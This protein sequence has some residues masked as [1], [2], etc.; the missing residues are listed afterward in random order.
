MAKAVPD[1]P[2]DDAG[3]HYDATPYLPARGGLPALRRAASACRGCPLFRDATQTVFGRGPA[4]ARLMLVGEQPGDREDVQG[5]PFVGP[6]GQLLRR[7]L[8][9]AGLDGEEAYLTNVVKHF[10]FTPAP[11]GK[12]RI[13]QAPSLREMTACRPWLARELRLVA[14]E[15]LVV[16]GATAG[17]ALLGPS[18]RVGEQRGVL[19]PMPALD[20]E[21]PGTAAAGQLLATVHPSAV[22]RADD[23]EAAFAGLVADLSVAATVLE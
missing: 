18:F 4:R 13:H 2:G 6:A 14:P 16:L 10:K 11:R 15:V 22:L 23:R 12:R 8:D 17:K 5:E 3:Q 21:E 7:A 19:L 1:A 9:E 20:G